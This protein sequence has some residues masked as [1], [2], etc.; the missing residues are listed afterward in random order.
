MVSFYLVTVRTVEKARKNNMC[1]GMANGGKTKVDKVENFIRETNE[2]HR[3]AE[4]NANEI[5]RLQAENE[6][7]HN[8]L[9]SKVEYIHEQ[10]EIIE[11]KKAEIERLKKHSETVAKEVQDKMTCMCGCKNCIETVTRIIKDDTEPF[12]RQCNNCNRCKEIKAEVI[13]EFA[14]RL[15]SEIKEEFDDC[16]C[17]TLYTGI[18]NLVKEMVG[19][20][21]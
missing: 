13:K 4:L 12:D 14:E 15:K 8:E 10:L 7:L 20:G 16:L 6:R 17:L 19:E 2:W 18:D 11:S 1:L 9:H 3:V 21:K 5:I